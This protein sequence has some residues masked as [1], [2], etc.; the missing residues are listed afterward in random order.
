MTIHNPGEARHAAALIDALLAK[1]CMLSVHEGEDWAI[2]HS[3]DRAAILEALA[4]TDEDR[5]IARSTD[6][7]ERLGSFYLVYGNAPDELIADHTDNEFCNAIWTEL[8]PVRAE[9]E[10]R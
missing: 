6:G 3:T 1:G 9:L 2:Q 10:A 7:T 8:E 4:S 5:V